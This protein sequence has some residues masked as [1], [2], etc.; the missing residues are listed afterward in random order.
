MA[1]SDNPRA[2]K[3][4]IISELLCYASYK[5]SKLPLA[6]LKSVI[7]DFYSPDDISSAKD[8][9]IGSVDKIVSDKWP[10]PAK[11]K[12]SD[13]KS[14]IEVDDIV[15]V[16]TYLDENLLRSKLL[17]FVA[18][19]V[20]NIPSNRIEEGDMRCFLAKLDNLDKKVTSVAESVSVGLAKAV[21]QN[22]DTVTRPSSASGLTSASG[23]AGALWSDIVA[24]P[25][26]QAKGGSMR[27]ATTATGTDTETEDMQHDGYTTVSRKKRRFNSPTNQN[28][29]EDGGHGSR[30]IG[31]QTIRFKPKTVIGSN[32]SATLKAA[33]ELLNKKVFCVSN[34]SVDTSCDDIKSIVESFGIKVFSVYVVNTKFENSA[35]FRVCIDAAHIDKFVDQGN[36]GEHIVVREW[37]FKPKG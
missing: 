23:R 10:K 27:I 14:R 32:V 3:P 17:T 34:I 29:N 11:R 9:L 19:N 4:I 1:D 26:N 33:K 24:S 28:T 25:G 15:G 21:H 31:Q 37:V 2:D 5:F 36:W 35:S 13:S 7:S 30:N 22:I 12:L 20:E 6:T 16:Y 18:V 8:I